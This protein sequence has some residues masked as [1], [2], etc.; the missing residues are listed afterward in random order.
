[1][2]TLKGMRPRRRCEK[3]LLVTRINV[4]LLR[5]HAKQEGCK[6]RG[7]GEWMGDVEMLDAEGEESNRGR[8][9]VVMVERKVW[10]LRS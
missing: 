5:R 9:K 4:T 3:R 10:R 7:R 2:A 1:M 6:G 8:W